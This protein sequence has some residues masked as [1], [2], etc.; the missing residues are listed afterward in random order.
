MV[1]EGGEEV[2]VVNAN[3]QAGAL[4]SWHNVV[5]VVHGGPE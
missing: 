2:D 3:A 4:L 5:F 1:W